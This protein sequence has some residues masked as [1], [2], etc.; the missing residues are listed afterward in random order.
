[1]K[2]QI[3]YNFND[4]IIKKNNIKKITKRVERI[5]KATPKLIFLLYFGKY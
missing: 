1:M 4:G 2:T 5:N 3:I